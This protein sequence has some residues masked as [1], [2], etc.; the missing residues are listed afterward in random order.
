M[1]LWELGKGSIY[2][3]ASP[4]L[5]LYKCL[6]LPSDPWMSMSFLEAS[7]MLTQ[8][9]IISKGPWDII[10]DSGSAP[11]SMLF[12]LFSLWNVLNPGGLYI[13][14]N[15]HANFGVDQPASRIL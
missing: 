4:I 5:M 1:D 14:Q 8:D 7:L 6:D 2:V 9:F 13:L 10:I 15:L 11:S 12:P 3:S